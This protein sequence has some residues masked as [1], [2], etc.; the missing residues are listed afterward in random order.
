MTAPTAGYVL[1][2]G[3]SS[4]F[5]A[6]KALLDWHGRPLVLHVAAQVAQAAGSVTLVGAPDRYLAL[7]LPV[8]PDPVT[9]FGPLA[10]LWAAL[11]HSQA[12]WNLVVACD[13]PHLHAA[14]LADLLH[15]ANAE[16]PDVLLPVDHQGRPEPLC[17]VYSLRSLPLQ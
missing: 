17:A 3:R 15:R 8:I 2:G 5:G 12:D 4:R 9:G 11:D 6:D 7:G 10:G 14:F 1:V 16:D 13:L